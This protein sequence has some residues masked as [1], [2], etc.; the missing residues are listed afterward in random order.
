MVVEHDMEF[1]KALDC[2]VTVLHE[3]SVLAEGSHS[4]V[5]T[6]DAVIEVYLG[7]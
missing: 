5:Q 6:N 7:R 3:G 1:V 4:E 2:K